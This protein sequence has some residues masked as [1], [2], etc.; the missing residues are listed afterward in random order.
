MNHLDFHILN[1]S[2]CRHTH[3]YPQIILPLLETLHIWIG[4]RGYQIAPREICFIP[5][6][7]QHQCQFDSSLLVIDIPPSLIS[8]KD[9]ALLNR[10]LIVPPRAQLEPLISLIRA[11]INDNPNSSC[12][13]YLYYYLYSKLVENRSTASLRYISEHYD[14][15]ISVAQL[16]EMENYNITYFNEW[17]KTQTGFSPSLYLRHTR[18]GKAKELLIATDF[19]IVEIAVMVGYASHS[20]FTRAFKGLT[21]LTPQEFRALHRRVF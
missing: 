2:R 7:I 10:P 8:K 3:D 15:P 16:A 19:E 17:F 14:E 4:D 9:A 6:N 1:E 5:P 20:A 18:I 12:I 11:E 13:H 21:G